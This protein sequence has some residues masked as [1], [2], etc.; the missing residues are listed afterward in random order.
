LTVTI[1]AD[2][3]AENDANPATTATLRRNTDTTNP[4]DVT[5]TSDVTSKATVLDT[6]TIPADADTVSFDITA[7]D[8]TVNDGTRLVTIQASAS[9]FQAGSDTV[10][11]TD[12][13][14]PQLSLSFT[15]PRISQGSPKVRH[16]RPPLPQ[17]LGRIPTRSL[18]S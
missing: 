14:L 13:D 15:T 7:V 2:V 11:V 9:G 1:V 12:D 3:F 16:R 18:K 17:L 10:N 5:L 4:L 6:V 8:N